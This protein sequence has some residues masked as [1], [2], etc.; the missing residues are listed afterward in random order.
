MTYQAFFRIGI[1]AFVALGL[2]GC[3]ALPQSPAS[4]AAAGSETVQVADAA[5]EAGSYE[6]A[7]RLY[8]RAA[9]KDSNLTPAYLGLGRSYMA[10]GQFSRARFALRRAETLNKRNPDVHNELGNLELRQ[11]RPAEAIVH[12]DQALRRQRN[13]LSALTGKA[14]S[15]DFLSRHLDA[16]VVYKQ[17]LAT[18]PTNFVLLSNYALSLALSGQVGEGISIMQELLRDPKQGDAVRS[19]MAIAYALAGRERDARAMLE[20]TMSAA[21][22]EETLAQYRKMARAYRAGKPI[23]F[24]VFN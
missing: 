19:N 21:E 11:L 3:G 24:M 13:N 2:A 20:G 23:G 15:L 9:Q 17:A 14:V 16:Q 4:G 5:F 10:M 8:E 18:Y 7:I 6:E 1:A 12:F 22:I